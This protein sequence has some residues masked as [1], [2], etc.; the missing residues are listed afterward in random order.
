MKIII[1]FIAVAFSDLISYNRYNNKVNQFLH[2]RLRYS[3]NQVIPV[4]DA[5]K[6]KL[7]LA[8]LKNHQTESAA[9]L[10]ETTDNTYNRL[11]RNKATKR[12][13]LDRFLKTHMRH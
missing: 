12:N 8:K 13:R 4:A 2:T 6:L 10:L 3:T 7:I 5:K 11:L 9:D 1:A